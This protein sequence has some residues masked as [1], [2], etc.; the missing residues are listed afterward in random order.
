MIEDDIWFIIIFI[1]NVMAFVKFYFSAHAF[2][3]HAFDLTKFA[4]VR[5]IVLA[6]SFGIAMALLERFV[7]D[8]WISQFILNFIPFLGVC[9]LTKRHILDNIIIFAMMFIT[10]F[11]IQGTVMICLHLMD[12]SPEML[13]LSAQSL[14]LTAI[15]LMSLK[16][17]LY[18]AFAF[19]QRH[20]YLK[21]CI[22]LIVSI[23]L[24]AIAMINFD[25][26]YVWQQSTLFGVLIVTTLIGIVMTVVAAQRQIV[27]STDKYHDVV[28]MFTGL[29]L[30]IQSEDDIEELKKQSS[31]IAEYLTGRPPKT[32]VSNDYE[33]N[34]K[35][36][37]QD[38]LLTQGKS[39]QL[40]LDVD[41]FQHHVKVSF[42]KVSLMLGTLFDNALEHG[43]DE[44]IF[45]Y[46]NV[47][48][49]IF[50]LTVK[51]SCKEISP[52]KLKKLFKKGY[53][54][55][56]SSGHGHGLYKLQQ[57]VEKYNDNR[58]KAEVIVDTY[59]DMEYES[60]LFEITVD[61]STTN[62]KRMPQ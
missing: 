20:L 59:Y 37:L 29:H 10:I 44:L 17:K 43:L 31:E 35:A 32:I 24:V 25:F 42:P 60:H 57:E 49:D 36:M 3:G 5:N 46:M 27:E 33:R 28:N 53:T 22:Y 62:T 4:I 13:L 47:S 41:Y 8:G 15:I 21:V 54:T 52:K 58:Y 39:S 19:V 51:N 48:E 16:V 34:L 2:G 26:K 7:G 45:V 55:K 11:I 14:T 9:Y 56:E 6:L 18:D 30:S 12:L 40:T 23:F 38:K 50:E 1:A 61:I